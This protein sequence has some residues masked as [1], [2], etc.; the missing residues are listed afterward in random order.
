MEQHDQ[1]PQQHTP[2]PDST[3]TTTPGF[4]PA[5]DPFTSMGTHVINL[6]AEVEDRLGKLRQASTETVATAESLQH[7]QRALE[8]NQRAL[9]QLEAELTQ[10]RSAL[11]A[12]REELQTLQA[13]IEAARTQQEGE[14][15]E[16]ERRWNE[17]NAARADLQKAQEQLAQAQSH[18][19][20][21]REQ[22]AAGR[23][24]L[25][26]Q[27]E[28]L[29]RKDQELS[30]EMETLR[31][32]LD[33]E[34]TRFTEEQ[35]ATQAA[36]AQKQSELEQ[37]SLRA[38]SLAA[39]LSEAQN[40]LADAQ[41]EL[42]TLRTQIA[43]AQSE[44]AARDAS[45]ADL[46]SQLANAWSRV[47]KTSAELRA[48]IATLE[49]DLRSARSGAP[50]AE[51]H[52]EEIARRDTELARRAS[53][54]RTLQDEVDRLRK[55]IEAHQSSAGSSAADAS[56]GEALQKELQRRDDAIAEMATHIR[57][58][59][60]SLSAHKA[61]LAEA[62]K[63]AAGGVIDVGAYET[64]IASL[65]QQLQE[66]QQRAQH[67]AAPAS[68][69]PQRDQQ[70][71]RRLQ[72]FRELLVARA[73]KL[74]VAQQSVAQQARAVVQARQQAGSAQGMS[75]DE[76]EKLRSQRQTLAEVHASLEKAERRMI[77]RWARARSVTVMFLFTAVTLTVA[78]ASYFSV[79]QFAPVP[80]AAHATVQ[81]FGRPGF[82][83]TDE[84]YAGWQTFMET[85]L[86][87]D[88][89]LNDVAQRLGQRGMSDLATEASLRPYLAAGLTF[90]FPEPGMLNLQLVD[91][92]QAQAQRV[93]E[94]LSLAVVSQTMGSELHR[95]DGARAK[96]AVPATV[97]PAPLQDNR[98]TLVG[99]VFGAA[100]GAVL[101]VGLVAYGSMG[102][103][104][105]V[106]QEEDELF[107][108]LLE[109][110][111]WEQVVEAKTNSQEHVIE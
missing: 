64:R 30:A 10:S 47:E 72:Q 89:L 18:S 76:L 32:A 42:E 87:G 67:S 73:D 8:E 39:D 95:T 108:P 45:V 40:A 12:Q 35:Q 94:T 28:A 88:R 105:R 41:A 85:A 74:R 54:L 82:P 53:E 48:R 14:C 13:S 104:R 49:Q 101:L 17:L 68:A 98:L 1:T 16:I 20:Q 34:R 5:T 107:E 79:M 78:A 90:E 83:L 92:D 57:N 23:R 11:D 80:Y 102:R 84:Q 37:A 91:S 56:A 29:T 6:I 86:S 43:Q 33:A 111:R 38:D 77:R 110:A 93:L 71:R 7:K 46:E 44:L 50:D 109:D 25:E 26:A 70:R 62:Q 36:L 3:P 27:R 9:E 106:L 65:E 15:R 21:E 103:V 22:I 96:V 31:R 51:T 55:Q 58:L 60:E 99:Y 4:T 2:S 81:A 69:T 19:E 75:R 52:A 24:D 97:D 63:A 100:M 61:K 66:A 59:Q